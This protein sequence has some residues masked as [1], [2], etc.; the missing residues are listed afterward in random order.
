M[1]AKRKTA[2]GGAPSGGVVARLRGIV[3]SLLPAEAKVA[4]LVVDNA[5]SILSQPVGQ[6][7]RDAGVS[8]ATVIRFCR[9]AG[10]SGFQ[11]MKI[12]LAR[13]TVSPIASALHED[14]SEKDEAGAIARKVFAANI[15]TLNDTLGV[16]DPSAVERATALVG[17]AGKV[18]IIGVGTSAPVAYDAYAKLM[19][20]GVPATLQTDAHLQMMEAALLKRGDVILAISHSGA[21][22]DPVET[23]AVGRGAG[24]KVVSITNNGMSPLSRAS[25][26]TL[27]TASKETRFRSEALSSRIAQAA[28]LDLLYVTIGLANKRRALSSAKKIEDVITS[29]QY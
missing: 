19:R 15:D 8:E 23:V 12:A 21:T 17:K 24:A 20:L 25:D 6:V 14:V 3:P 22:K 18:L 13:E 29:K 9:T 5:E 26:V 4:R 28:V 1:N 27:L 10:F 11:S 2:K 7:A 16:L